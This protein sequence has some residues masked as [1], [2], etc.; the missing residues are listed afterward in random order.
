MRI[1]SGTHKGRVV[2]PGKFFSDRPTTDIAKEGLFNILTNTIDFDELNVLE[3]FA[4]SG[5][6]SYEFAS[7]GAA[8][9]LA[10]EMNFK[11]VQFIKNTIDDLG[12]SNIKVQKSDVFRFIRSNKKQFDLV[13]ADPPY[14]MT[15]LADLPDLVCSNNMLSPEGLF[16]LEHPQQYNFSSHPY[17]HSLRKYGT[18]HFS[19]FKI[20]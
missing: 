5:N 14:A 18:V 11:Y 2:R 16:I 1:V 17:F 15:K 4:G 7:R 13:F 10:V 6:I 19:F 12:F 20:S 9:I 3:L 8:S